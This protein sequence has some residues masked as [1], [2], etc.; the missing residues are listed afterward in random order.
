MAFEG[1]S[2]ISVEVSDGVARATLDH[3][4][5]NLFD[6]TLMG[7]VDRLGR[8]IEADDSVRV[9][10]FQ[11]ANPDFFIA[12]ADVEL[13]QRLPSDVPEKSTELNFF[14]AMVERFRQMPKVS[15]GK[16]EGCA[17]GGGSEFLLSL[18]MRF[19]TI[20][21]CVV[22]QPEVALGILP[23]GSGTQRLPGLMG[24]GRALEVVLGCEDFDA[25]TAERYG[26]INRAFPEGEVG[27]FV[28][29]L[30][31]RIATFPPQAIALA[32]RAVEAAEGPTREG[33][34]EEAWCFQ[35]TLGLEETK[36]RLAQFLKHGGQTREVELELAGILDGLGRSESESGK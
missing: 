7:E 29:A 11:S 22:S 13:I 25:E 24:R 30:A 23:G 16:I 21:R 14:H 4:P 18:D 2:C 31:R 32:K 26:W 9:V 36:S 1:Y 10:V 34:L 6:V 5:I 3:P 12:H 15:I 19:G 8:E 20:G 35:Q 33:L 27:P 28:D 17:R